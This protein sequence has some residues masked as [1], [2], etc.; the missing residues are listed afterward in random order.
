[1]ILITGVSHNTT[2][3]EVWVVMSYLVNPNSSYY[4]R[5]HEHIDYASASIISQDIN[6]STILVLYFEHQLKGSRNCRR[7]NGT[8]IFLDRIKF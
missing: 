1:M 4:Q 7:K 5:E 8:L 3:G 6:I 2:P